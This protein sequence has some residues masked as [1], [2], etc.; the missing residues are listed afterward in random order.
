M[1]LV[2][3]ASV[4]SV[5]CGDA[6][7]RV[8]LGRSPDV[9]VATPAPTTTTTAPV[10]P[11]PPPPPT[12]PAPTPTASPTPVPVVPA[13]AAPVTVA[14][15]TAPAIERVVVDTGFAPYALAEGVVLR[16]P[17]SRVERIGFHQSGH[18]GA[19]QQQ[20]MASAARPFTMSSR[21]RGTGNQTAADIVVQPDTEIRAP[22]SGTVTRGGRYT[23]YCDNVDEYVVIEPDG[24]PG[25]EVKILHFEGLAVAKGQR[26]E[27]GET[28]IAARSRVLS[29]ASQVDEV[30][31]QPSWPHVHIEVV[32]PSIPDRP[33][34]GGGCP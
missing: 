7:V 12:A 24:R 30:T 2:F 1:T 32:D 29:F 3:V 8:A 5:S 16:H 26:V 10:E 15:T 9:I 21:A 17:A 4:F 11:P 31:A 25:W 20:V 14:P 34:G 28:V 27:A 19:R 6:E 22:V 18:D 13:T 33:S 23:L